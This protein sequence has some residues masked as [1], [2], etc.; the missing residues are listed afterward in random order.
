MISADNNKLHIATSKHNRF[1]TSIIKNR[2]NKLTYHIP[3][4]LS[5]T[6]ATYSEKRWSTKCNQKEVLWSVLYIL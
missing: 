1:A 6:S 5:V 2:Q 4:K 3:A